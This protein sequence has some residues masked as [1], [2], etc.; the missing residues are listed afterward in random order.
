MIGTLN[1]AEKEVTIVGAGISGLLAAYVLDKRGYKVTLIEEKERAG[2]LIE[3]KQT[4]YGIA[5]TAA[6]SFLATSAVTNLCN[7][8]GIELLPVRKDSKARYILRDGKPSRLP[9][10]FL[11]LASTIKHATFLK[12][13]NSSENLTLDQWANRH[14]GKAALEYLLSPFVRGVYGAEPSELGV[15]TAFPSLN[16]KV[17]NTLI[18][19]LFYKPSKASPTK[20]T[21]KSKKQ[22]VVPRGGMG[23]LIGKLEGYLEKSLKDRFIK[24]TSISEIPKSPNI[25]LTVPAYVAADLLSSISPELSKELRKIRYTPLVSVNAFF[26]RGAFEKIP[27]GVG[28]LVPACEERKI[29]GVLYNSSSFEDRVSDESRWISLTIMM[30]G[31]SNPQIVSSSDQTIEA[32]VQDELS[33]ILGAK[34]KPI[35]MVINRWQR[36]IPQYSPHLATVWEVARKTWCANSGQILFGNYTGQVSIRGMIEN[37]IS[38]E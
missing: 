20:D 34:E 30:G 24:G 25:I 18:G 36:G 15:Q 5:E 28:V 12:A 3:T 27:R 21:N 13:E 31:T 38:L 16:V 22:M 9:L 7:E 14:L 32:I 19:T 10:T 8:L 1:Q 4:E 6:H 37:A 23:E 29:L 35:H 33:Q 2:G 26:E 11:E 17:G